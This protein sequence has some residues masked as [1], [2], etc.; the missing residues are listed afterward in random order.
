MG[1]AGRG[2]SRS[3][4]L[5]PF[6]VWEED[7]VGKSRSS[8]WASSDRTCEKYRQSLKKLKYNIWQKSQH[9]A[10]EREHIFVFPV[11]CP[12]PAPPQESATS[13]TAKGRRFSRG[14]G[15][16]FRAQMLRFLPNIPLQLFETLP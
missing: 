1:V 16:A 12:P 7:C 14:A 13:K 2:L 6:I 8:V 10:G 4:V 3:R 9:R 5:P 15:F 11:K